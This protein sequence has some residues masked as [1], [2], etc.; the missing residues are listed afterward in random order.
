M[1]RLPSRFSGSAAKYIE[2]KLER[3][4][5]RPAGPRSS[6]IGRGSGFRLDDGEEK[7]FEQIGLEL[8]TNLPKSNL[9]HPWAGSGY[10]LP[11]REFELPYSISLFRTTEAHAIKKSVEKRRAMMSTGSVE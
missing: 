1:H 6:E 3:M 5:L 11:R 2:S 8:G 9:A 4:G 10:R 7:R